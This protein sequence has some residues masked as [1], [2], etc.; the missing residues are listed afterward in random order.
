MSREKAQTRYSGWKKVPSLQFRRTP[1]PWV[2]WQKEASQEPFGNSP[3]SLQMQVSW[4]TVVGSVEKLVDV[5]KLFSSFARE[6]ERATEKS[7]WTILCLTVLKTRLVVLIDRFSCLLWPLAG[8]LAHTGPHEEWRR[9][10][11]IVEVVIMKSCPKCVAKLMG[12]KG[13]VWCPIPWILVL[14]I[15]R[16]K[17]LGKQRNRPTAV[18]IFT[19]FLLFVS[20]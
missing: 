6:T 20:L 8:R 13:T 3:S 17:N 11:P 10:L 2:Q 19:K 12:Q 9:P 16:V 18:F 15:Q 4:S 14:L 1:T 5:D 7:L